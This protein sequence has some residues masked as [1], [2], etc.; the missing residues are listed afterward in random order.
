M[1][2]EDQILEILLEINQESLHQEVDAQEDQILEIL[3]EINQMLPL[4]LVVKNSDQSRISYQNYPPKQLKKL[5]FNLGKKF[6]VP[7][8]KMQLKNTNY[9]WCN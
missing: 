4:D 5:A 3:L 2:L 8:I 9:W 6:V 1:V 7:L